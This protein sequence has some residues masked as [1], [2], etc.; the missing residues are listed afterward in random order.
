MFFDLNEFWF[1]S[2]GGDSITAVSTSNLVDH[3]NAD[4]VD[5]LPLTGCDTTS[6]MSTKT[7]AFKTA[8]K[9]GYELLWFFGKTEI[10]NEVIGDAEKFFLICICNKN[11]D[12]F[13]DLE[14]KLNHKRL[15]QFNLEKFPPLSSSIRKHIIW[16]C[17]HGRLWLHAPF[18]KDVSGD[19][20]K[21]RCMFNDKDHLTP[22]INPQLAVPLD[23]PSPCNCLKFAQA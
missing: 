16:V 23:F 8:S 13:N 19:P 3:R 6:N 21:Y 9:C 22:I 2:G 5:I 18:I 10:A 12:K 17:W 11:L 20:L 14:Y 7:A 15:H 4:V 1:I